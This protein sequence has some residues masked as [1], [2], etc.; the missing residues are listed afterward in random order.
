MRTCFLAYALGLLLGSLIPMAG[1]S[2]GP[3]ILIDLNP[4]VQNLLHIPAFM[5]LFVLGA[6]AFQGMRKSKRY[7]FLGLAVVIYGIFLESVQVF[8]PGRYVSLLDVLLNSS[9]VILGAILV[10]YVRKRAA[11]KSSVH[12]SQSHSR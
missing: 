3:R 4:G 5:G 2:A 12:H 7:V 11:K 10:C 6:S 1:D 9:G 8:V